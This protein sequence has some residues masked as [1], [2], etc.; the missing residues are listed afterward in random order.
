[1][2]GAEGILGD[3]LQDEARR[4]RAR[5]EAVVELHRESLWRYCRRLTGSIWDAEDLAQDTIARALGRLAYFGQAL[6]PRAY[7]FRIATNAWLDQQKRATPDSLETLDDLAAPAVSESAGDVSDAMTEVVAALS[8]RQ[9]VVWLLV[10]A[11]SFQPTEVAAMVGTTQGAVK[12]MLHRARGALERHHRSVSVRRGL[13][14]PD[15]VVQRYLDAFNRRDVDGLAAL[16]NDDATNIIPGDWEEHGVDTMRRWSLRY[17]QAEPSVE[18]AEWA[19]V[20]GEECVLVMTTDPQGVEKLWSIIRL[21]IVD[22]KIVTHRWYFFCPELLGHVAAQLGVEAAAHGYISP[23][24]PLA[25]PK[26]T[27]IDSRP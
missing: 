4:L 8:P 17:W 9:R 12:A 20:D 21:D 2:N 10:E 1:M 14:P 15:R 11:F 25:A 27:S 23:Y 16:F 3:D 18:R 19:S 5:F 24:E 22:D 26:D 6:N 7:L 13:R